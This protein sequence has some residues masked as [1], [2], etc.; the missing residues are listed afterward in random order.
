MLLDIDS[1]NAHV[2]NHGYIHGGLN[3]IAADL[4]TDGAFINNA[5]TVDSD[6]AGIFVD[7]HLGALTT[8]I[9]N[10]GTIHGSFNAIRASAGAFSLANQGT[11]IGDVVSFAA[12]AADTIVNAGKIMGDV[13]L[14]AG[15]DTFNGVGGASGS[16][17]GE[18]GAD[19][20]IGGSSGDRMDGG[21]GSDTLTGGAGADHFLFSTALVAN[22]DRI[23]DFKHGVDKFD[24]DHVIFGAAGAAGTGL[25]AAAF[26][27]GAHAHD[28]S[29]RIIYNPANGF[30]LYDSNGSGAGHE[31]HFATLAHN[32]ALSQLDFLIT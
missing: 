19:R 10:T 5:G 14:G 20:L 22:I 8:T 3:G 28:A 9:I 24:L 30:V 6:F 11:L 16:I 27:K 26:F 23:T 4:N 13:H 1:D 12:A 2:L 15:G 29:D 7:T 25:S 18:A 21:D 32:L 31:V 17:Y